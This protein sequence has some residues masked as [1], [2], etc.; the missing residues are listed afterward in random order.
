MSRFADV[1]ERQLIMKEKTDLS[2][3]DKN[4]KNWD[5]LPDLQKR[6]IILVSLPDDLVVPKKTTEIMLATIRSGTG[7]RT[8]QL[9]HHELRL[10]GYIVN[11]DVGFCASLKNNYW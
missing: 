4:A 11:S 8:P 7:A 9:L 5:N 2:P 10:K 6:T 3:P 1:V